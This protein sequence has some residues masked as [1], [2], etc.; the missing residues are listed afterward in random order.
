ME[1]EIETVEIEIVNSEWKEDGP[2][3]E[4]LL[5]KDQETKGEA[6]QGKG[7]WESWA[8]CSLTEADLRGY[9]TI[10]NSVGYIVYNGIHSE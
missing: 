1:R 7:G 8:P 9:P 2:S 3:E 6:E 4:K 10:R 5:E